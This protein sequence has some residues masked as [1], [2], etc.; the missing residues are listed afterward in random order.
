MKGVGDVFA[1]HKFFYSSEL[2]ACM[3]FCCIFLCFSECIFYLVYTACKK[4]NNFSRRAS[5]MQEMPLQRSK[6]FAGE[7]AFWPPR[8]LHHK[9]LRRSRNKILNAPLCA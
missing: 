3:D 5:T 4:M 7:H 9:L 8:I 2:K 6:I 1:I